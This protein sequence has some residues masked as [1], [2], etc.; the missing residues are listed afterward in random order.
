MK[1]NIYEHQND[2]A[3][4]LNKLKNGTDIRGIAIDTEEDDKILTPGIVS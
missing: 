4:I 2:A 3:I 1:N